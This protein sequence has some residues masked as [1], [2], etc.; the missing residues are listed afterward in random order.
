[1]I[2]KVETINGVKQ[3]TPLDDTLIPNISPATPNNSILQYEN[4]VVKS[5]GYTTGEVAMKANTVTKLDFD[6]TPT[7][8]P[9]N[10]PTANLADALNQLGASLPGIGTY[11]GRLTYTG[12]WHSEYL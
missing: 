2:G 7:G 12:Y 6:A 3:I 1:M 5:A 11:A 10:F 8:S 9:S 4:G